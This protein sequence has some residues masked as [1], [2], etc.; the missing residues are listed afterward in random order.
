M[1]IEQIPTDDLIP[2]AKNAKLHSAAQ[3]SSIA[4]SIKE[5]GFNNP[6]LIDKDNGIIAGHGRVLAAQKLKMKAVP[7]VRLGHLTEN[8]KRAYII[9]DNRL[10][11]RAEWDMEML[12]MEIESIDF[13]DFKDFN[14]D[15]LGE[16]EFNKDVFDASEQMAPELPEGDRAPFRQMTFTVHDEQFEEVEAAIKKAKEEGGSES[17]VNENSNG[18]ALAWICGV[19]NRG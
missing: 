18:N 14:I 4:G 16:F 12:K 6:V 19:F 1:K 10:A 13:G 9:A 17:A 7:C 2:Y 8:Q 5:F 3:V 11:E 15:D